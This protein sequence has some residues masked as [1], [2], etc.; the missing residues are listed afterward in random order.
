MG[1]NLSKSKGARLLYAEHEMKNII[2]V[3]FNHS[4]TLPKI[5]KKLLVRIAKFYA[6]HPL[7]INH[8]DHT[9]VTF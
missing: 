6:Q 3:A 8:S 2:N 4:P 5:N 9:Y 7:S 1:N